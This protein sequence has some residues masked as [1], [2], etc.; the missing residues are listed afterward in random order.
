MT[1]LTRSFKLTLPLMR[2]RDVIA[3]QRRLR[4]LGF[5]DVGQ[6]EGL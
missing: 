6:P 5:T 1:A 3:L 2:G 4:A